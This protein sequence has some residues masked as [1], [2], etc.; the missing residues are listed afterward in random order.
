M[1][2]ENRSSRSSAHAGVLAGE[3]ERSGDLWK[4][5]QATKNAS[6]GSMSKRRFKRTSEM[7]K[8]PEM[9]SRMG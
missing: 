5:T 9:L 2:K 3:E 7:K 6:E 8:V 4:L 1:Q